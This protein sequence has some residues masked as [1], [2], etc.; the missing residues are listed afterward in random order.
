MADLDDMIDR[1]Q[2]MDKV[3]RCVDKG[4]KERAPVDSVSYAA[5]GVHYPRGTVL[6]AMAIG[7]LDGEL[8][9]IDLIREDIGVEEACSIL[10]RYRIDTIVGSDD[11]DDTPVAHAVAGVISVLGRQ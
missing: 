1:Q 9:V 11:V 6:L 4:V 10:E 2:F 7:H 5:F 3:E 8:R